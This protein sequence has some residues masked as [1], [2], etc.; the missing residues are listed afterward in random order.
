MNDF[1]FKT[2]YDTTD[3]EFIVFAGSCADKDI[4]GIEI[5]DKTAFE[6]VENHIHIIEKIGVVKLFFYQ[7]KG[8]ELCSNVLL[9]LKQKYPT[10]DFI[11]YVTLTLHDAMI[12]RFH[13]KWEDETDYYSDT[14]PYKNTV[15][16]KMASVANKNT[17]YITNGTVFGGIM[18]AFISGRSY[19]LKQSFNQ[20]TI[21]GRR[22]QDD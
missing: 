13:Q 21:R 22:S 17:L 11:V 1:D 5:T 12:L 3:N 7:R 9:S 20:I 16:I 10:R 8:V 19:R 4:S 6:A 14:V 15:L 2:I 18:N